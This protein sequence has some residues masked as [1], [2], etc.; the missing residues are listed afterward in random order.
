MTQALATIDTVQPS[1]TDA[2]FIAPALV[3][4][5]RA[6]DALTLLERARPRGAQLWFYLRSRAFDPVRGEPRFQVVWREADPR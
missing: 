5:G 3:A 1:P 2:R 6:A 4:V